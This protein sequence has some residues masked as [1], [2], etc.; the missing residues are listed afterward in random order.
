MATY[1]VLA[2]FTDQ[3]VRNVK[4]SPYRLAAFRAMA[5]KMGVKMTSSC[6]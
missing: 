6:L 3:G 2:N 4:D 5:G 1:V